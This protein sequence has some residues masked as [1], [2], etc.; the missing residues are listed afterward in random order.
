MSAIN[1]LYKKSNFTIQKSINLEDALYT[2]LKELEQEYD[3]T[4]SELVNVCIEDLVTIGKIKYLAKPENESLIYRSL[5]LRKDNIDAL[6]KINQEQ[7]ISFTRLINISIREFLDK[8]DKKS[9]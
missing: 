9:K 7:G 1:R 4:I 5:M 6:L 8:Y 3:A 2:R